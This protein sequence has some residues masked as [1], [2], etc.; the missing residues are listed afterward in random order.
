MAC[1][2]RFSLLLFLVWGLTACGSF[3]VNPELK[4]VDR[5]KG[6]RFKNLEKGAGNTDSLFVVVT[7]SG[8][9]TRAAALSYGVL[10]ALK[11]TRINWKG[12][13]KSLLDEV[14]M[15]S[16]VSGG[17]FTA[18]YY[19]LHRDG[20]FD[21]EFERRFLKQDVQGDLTK[22]L[23]N[24]ANWFKLAGKS[25][26]R[27]D[28]AAEYYNRHIFDGATYG[29]IADQR[30][31]PFVMLNAT[32]MTLG[33]QFQFIQD[34]FDLI[35]SDLSGLQVARA[36]ATSSAFPGLLTP[37]TYKNFAD[38]CGIRNSDYPWVSAALKQQLREQRVNA[39]RVIRAEDRRSYY[40]PDPYAE[41]R[42]DY[43]HL[44][45]GGVADNI[46]LRGPLNA[47]SSTDP[48][49][50]VMELIN[51][52][53]IEKLLVIVVNAATNP[54]TARDKKASVPG[55]LDN[56]TT[57]ATVP[58]DNYSV[59]TVELLKG[60]FNQFN[61][62]YQY[63]EQCQG[64]LEQTCAKSPVDA[65]QLNAVDLY[66]AEVAFDFIADDRERQWFKNLATSFSLPAGTVDKLEDVG[67]SLYASDPQL[68][69]LLAGD[70]GFTGQKLTGKVPECKKPAN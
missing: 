53:K 17:S 40:D 41:G 49:Y 13:E 48:A 70:A 68:R 65:S 19:A 8:G 57:A 45:D 4:Q 69:K 64:L 56:V 63:L 43:V 1:V 10:D 62:S 22:L 5:E 27:S 21:G 18:A 15:I 11:R 3:P 34:Q 55:L 6:Y 51:N 12:E 42:R 16:S 52:R 24:P 20:I 61:A 59:D 7:F 23:L 30:L 50:S 46:G 26:G 36:V 31:R 14:D 33:A 67:C 60:Y 25:F 28:L 32:D 2:S 9:G 47:L 39:D 38:G 37:L 29:A 44:V 54:D 35:C 58:L 66:V